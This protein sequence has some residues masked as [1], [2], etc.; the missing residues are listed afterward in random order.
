MPITNEFHP[1]HSLLLTLAR[2]LIGAMFF[3]ID[4]FGWKWAFNLT[5]GV[6]DVS[7]PV[8]S[9]SFCR[10]SRNVQDHNGGR[11]QTTL[12]GASVLTAIG[13]PSCLNRIIYRQALK[14]PFEPVQASCGFGLWPLNSVG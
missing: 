14:A 8:A 1:T 9:R 13:S 5:V 3:G 6:I 2:L 10:S 12:L 11:N 7:G 4:A